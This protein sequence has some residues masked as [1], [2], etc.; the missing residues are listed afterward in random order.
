[1]DRYAGAGDEAAD[2]ARQQ[3]RHYQLLSALQSLVKELPRCAAA[4]GRGRG[5]GPRSRSRAGPPQLLSAA[6]V[7]HHAQRLGPGAAGRHGVRDRAGA[8]GDP[9]PHR[10][11]PVQPATAAA[12]RTPRCGGVAGPSQGVPGRRSLGWM[13]RGCR[14]ALTLL[15]CCRKTSYS[16]SPV[17]HTLVGRMSLLVGPLTAPRY[18]LANPLFQG[19]PV[20]VSGLISLG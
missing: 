20:S 3:E 5:P 8:S 4:G 9:A 18:R 14:V 11:E 12:E 16:G 19:L 15:A 7:L 6:P 1:M 2:R 10:E 17:P 13:V